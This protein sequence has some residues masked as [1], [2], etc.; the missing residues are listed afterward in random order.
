MAEV[1]SGEAV[2]VSMWLRASVRMGGRGKALGLI[3]VKSQIIA[4]LE[5]SGFMKNHILRKIVRKI[6]H[7]FYFLPLILALLG[8]NW[9]IKSLYT[10]NVQIM[11][12]YIYIYTLGNDYQN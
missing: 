7:G 1:G 8:Y 5:K 3:R 4:H 10:Y 9:Q 12:L 2:G 6:K 11:F